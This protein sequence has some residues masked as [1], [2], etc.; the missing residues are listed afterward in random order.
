MRS[1]RLAVLLSSA[2]MCGVF[3]CAQA[4]TVQRLPQRLGEQAST[5]SESPQPASTWQARRLESAVAADGPASTFGAATT[6]ESEFALADVAPERLEA[7][8]RTLGELHARSAEGDAVVV[9]L[10]GDVLFDF[11]QSDLRADA[12]PVLDRVVALLA[13]F[14]ARAAVVGGH[15]DAKGG[16]AYNDA[17]SR[18]RAE[19]VHRY[20]AERDAAASARRYDVRGYGKR[21]PVAPNAHADGSDDPA[22]RQKN[23]RV[24]I[25]LKPIPS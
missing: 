8:K 18:R 15:T 6:P 10:P 12:L 23:R 1:R 16:D 7:T 22:G 21:R 3:A 5:W 9:D 24:E 19:S 2:A 25:V 13:A 20:L 4:L 11:D 14:P 17:L